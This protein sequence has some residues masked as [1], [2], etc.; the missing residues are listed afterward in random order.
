MILL[1]FWMKVTAV[2]GRWIYEYI[3]NC[4]CIDIVTN[5]ISKERMADMTKLPKAAFAFEYVWNPRYPTALHM[6]WGRK[7]TKTSGWFKISPKLE[8]PIK[9]KSNIKAHSYC[10]SKSFIYIY[11]YIYTYIYIYQRFFILIGTFVYTITISMT[12]ESSID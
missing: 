3:M 1:W 10:R 7:N 12:T 5:Q 9:C 11:I 2:S 6:A 8:K 4:A